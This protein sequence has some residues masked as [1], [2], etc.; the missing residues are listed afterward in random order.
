[1]DSSER[2]AKGQR[3]KN[4][5][6]KMFKIFFQRPSPKKSGPFDHEKYASTSWKT[7]LD[8]NQKKSGHIF[9]SPCEEW[10]LRVPFVLHPHEPPSM[11][12]PDFFFFGGEGASRGQNAIG[13][14]FLKILKM[15]DFLSFFLLG[16]KWVGGGGQSPRLGP[17]CPLGALNEFP[18][19]CLCIVT[20]KHTESL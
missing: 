1:M 20:K 7:G 6:Y 19:Q 17:P 9:S 14:R 15:C 13:E 3:E 12:A 18:H 8:S 16:T 5:T 4:D 10:L 11:A 2:L